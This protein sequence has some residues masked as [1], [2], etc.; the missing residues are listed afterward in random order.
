MSAVGSK[1][2]WVQWIAAVLV[3]AALIAGWVTL[4]FSLDTGEGEGESTELGSNTDAI[5]GNPEVLAIGNSL[6]YRGVDPRM[7]ERQLGVREAGVLTFSGSWAPAWYAGLKNKVFAHGKRPKLILVVNTLENVLRTDAPSGIRQTDLLRVM[8]PDEPVLQRKVFG[9]QAIGS[10]LQI[11]NAK[12][13][14]VG[15][16]LLDALKTA[17]F[18]VAGSRDPA[19]AA[20]AVFADVFQREG[21]T[22]TRL[23]QR[24]IPIV[25]VERERTRGQADPADSLLP[26]LVALAHE[27]GAR[28]VFAR[29]PVSRAG[30][31]EYPISPLDVERRAVALMNELG[32]GYLDLHGEQ[33]P[34]SVFLDD[35]HLN[36]TGQRNYTQLLVEGLKEI[37]ALD[38]APLPAAELPPWPPE[39]TR[40]GRPPP[41]PRVS[42]RAV[43]EGCR[44]TVKIGQYGHISDAR[45]S[46]IGVGAM[47]PLQLSLGDELI[48]GHQTPPLSAP[49]ATS[50][51][52]YEKAYYGWLSAVDLADR[53]PSLSWNPD[54][55]MLADDNA[56]PAWWVYP[57]TTL[58]LDFPE[59]DPADGDEATVVEVLALGLGGGPPA[60]IRVDGEPGVPRHRGIRYT[61]AIRVDHKPRKIQII[62]PSDGQFWLI[63]RIALRQGDRVTHVIGNPED[64]DTTVRLIGTGPGQ[65]PEVSADTVHELPP[66]PIEPPEFKGA[67]WTLQMT[68]YRRV[69]YQGLLSRVGVRDGIDPDDP[70]AHTA[71]QVIRFCSPLV[72]LEDGIP[73]VRQVVAER[74]Q[75]E[76]LGTFRHSRDRIEF[77]PSTS[78]A[79]DHV[80]TVQLSERR[81]CRGHLWLY[82]DDALTIENDTMATRLVTG[83]D[84]LQ[85]GG[86]IFGTRRQ[87]FVQV[88]V[89]SDAGHHLSQL[90]P[91]RRLEGEPL[92]LRLDRRLPPTPKNVRVR[93]STPDGGNALVLLNTVALQDLATSPPG[94]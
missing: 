66:G 82:P 56:P 11:L 33:F 35:I 38:E 32:A 87:A 80:Y 8:T 77:Y 3:P 81:E 78:S 7:L 52:H 42:R 24:L 55:P 15:I 92:N 20:D 59:P 47:S 43:V 62:A 16:T 22:D 37:G 69:S 13:G 18:A 30:R 50:S 61:D 34:D 45:L 10:P 49:C 25:E 31:V 26:D 2:G 21:A 67:P 54:L 14:G 48:R 27:H 65:A 36:L 71:M 64:L 73:L 28:V 86:F 12:R 84:T 58:T 89:D 63:R 44:V 83:A 40:T 60:E 6:T 9:N 74:F 53:D 46:E 85:L 76:N 17:P 5:D 72:L 88:E 75:P 57:G 94:R 19:G 79:D 51:Y 93:L 4:V 70:R 91:I 68:D 90:V 29:I 39:I 1:P 23:N 41:L